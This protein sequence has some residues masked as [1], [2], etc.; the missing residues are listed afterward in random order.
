MSTLWKPDAIARTQLHSGE[1]KEKIS[2]LK[3]DG[4]LKDL[5]CPFCGKEVMYRKDTNK[6][7]T[8]SGSGHQCK[9]MTVDNI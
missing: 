5:D 3:L 4:L 9:T 8:H 2:R 7:M 6:F 1:W